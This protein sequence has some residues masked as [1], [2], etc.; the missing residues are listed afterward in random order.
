VFELLKRAF[1][2]KRVD[3]KVW[4]LPA[5]L[6]I[7]GVMVLSFWLLRWM[8]TPVPPPQFTVLTAV[9]M[10][11]AFFFAGLGE[12]LGWTGYA[13]DPLQVRYHALQAGILLGLVTATW[14][15]LPLL[16]AERSPVWI[17]WWFLGA[18]S[19]RVLIVWIYNNAGKSVFVAAITHATYNLSWQLFPVN[20]SY[21]DPRLTSLIFAAAAIIVAIV[22]GPRTLTR[23]GAR[24]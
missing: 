23:S 20:G 12:E 8:S 10:F 24:S 9:V 16:Q 1:D 18:A 17:A 4:Y 22:W 15:I 5:F 14:H 7:P 21:Y 6:L 3:R 11:V 2:F 13:V 19:L